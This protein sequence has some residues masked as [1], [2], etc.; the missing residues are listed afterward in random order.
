MTNKS[1]PRSA[2]HVDE[3]LGKDAKQEA[4]PIAESILGHSFS[5][6]RCIEELLF[7]RLSNAL[8]A[9]KGTRAKGNTC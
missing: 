5:I 3:G 9:T 1:S 6:V 7:K 2:D 8:P 4:R